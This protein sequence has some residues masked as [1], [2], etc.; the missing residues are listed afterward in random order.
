MKI[1]FDVH[2]GHDI[3]THARLMHQKMLEKHDLP[4]ITGVTRALIPTWCDEC[5]ER[6][7]GPVLGG[8]VMCA[9]CTAKQAKKQTGF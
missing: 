8:P 7:W 2:D 5:S 4:R 1:L 3:E 6:A 9:D